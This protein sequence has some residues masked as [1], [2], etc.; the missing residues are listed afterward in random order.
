MAPED[1]PKVAKNAWWQER[2]A[3]Q[4]F[5]TVGPC[6]S[7]CKSQ[8]GLNPQICQLKAFQVPYLCPVYALS[9]TEGRAMGNPSLKPGTRSLIGC[10]PS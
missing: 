6:K 2:N 5:Q 1:F 10:D 8:A 3:N 9:A 7:R 4:A